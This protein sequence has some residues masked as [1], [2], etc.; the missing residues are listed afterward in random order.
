M[1]EDWYF[2]CCIKAS[3]SSTSAFLS[4]LETLENPETDRQLLYLA[5]SELQ[6]VDSWM[7]VYG[8][9]H[10][11]NSF[12]HPNFP[13]SKR[14][15][16]IKPYLDNLLETLLDNNTILKRLIKKLPGKLSDYEILD[17][18]RE[19]VQNYDARKHDHNPSQ[20]PYLDLKTFLSEIVILSI[21]DSEIQIRSD[22]L[23]KFSTQ[24]KNKERETYQFIR[25]CLDY[26][27]GRLPFIL[28]VSIAKNAGFESEELK[29]CFWQLSEHQSPCT[30]VLEPDLL[31][32]YIHNIYFNEIKK[33][34]S[35]KDGKTTAPY[36][37]IQEELLLLRHFSQLFNKSSKSMEP[38]S[39]LGFAENP[40]LLET[41]PVVYWQCI[42]WEVSAV[43]NITETAKALKNV[44]DIPQEVNKTLEVQYS[45]RQENE[46]WKQH[47]ESLLTLREPGSKINWTESSNSCILE[48]H[49]WLFVSPWIERYD[50]QPQRKIDNRYRTALKPENLIRL[51]VGLNIATKI[52]QTPKLKPSEGNPYR[53]FIIHASDIIHKVFGKWL[54]T[55][56]DGQNTDVIQLTLPLTGLAL[57]ADRETK[58]VG[59]GH[60]QSI[61]PESFV[62]IL[63]DASLEPIQNPIEQNFLDLVCPEVLI[64]WI[65]DAYP[66]AIRGR[67]SARWLSLISEVYGYY[68]SGKHPIGSRQEAALVVRFLSIL[69]DFNDYRPFDWRD[70]DKPRV[71]AH[72]RVLLLSSPDVTVTEWQDWDAYEKQLEGDWQLSSRIVRSLQ[73]LQTLAKEYPDRNTVPPDCRPWLSEW[74]H[75]LNAVSK[76]MG[77]DRFTRLLLVE[78]LDNPLLQDPDSQKQIAYILLEYGCAYDLQKLLDYAFP[79]GSKRDFCD[80]TIK[81]FDLQATIINAMQVFLE[82]QAQRFISGQELRNVQDPKITRIAFQKAELFQATL[83]KVAHLCSSYENERL[84]AFC[85]KSTQA[86]KDE[87]CRNEI[88]LR[89]SQYAVELKNNIKQVILP[90]K[91][92]ITDV[93]CEA[94]TYDPN[95]YV[96]NVLHYDFDLKGIKNFFSQDKKSENYCHPSSGVQELKVVAIAVGKKTADSNLGGAQYCYTFNCGLDRYYNYL[97]EELGPYVALTLKP[98]PEPESREWYVDSATSLIPQLKVGDIKKLSV[99]KRPDQENFTDII[100]RADGQKLKERQDYDLVYWKADTSWYFQ[101][102]SLSS[103]DDVFAQLDSDKKWRPY[104]HQFSDLVLD[105]V[106]ASGCQA[107]SGIITLCFINE[108]VNVLGDEAWRFSTAPG[109][110]F[111]IEKKKFDKESKKKISRE[112]KK[113]SKTFEIANGLLI[114]VRPVISSDNQEVYLELDRFERRNLEWR[115]LFS[116]SQSERNEVFLAERSN[117]DDGKWYYTLDD[118]VV[119]G[120]PEKVRVS[121]QKEREISSDR[122][123]IEFIVREWNPGEA[124]VK[125]DFVESFEV[126]PKNDWQDFFKR[127]ICYAASPYQTLLELRQDKVFPFRNENSSVLMCF[128]SDNILVQVQSESLSMKMLQIEDRL[129]KTRPRFRK[130]ETVSIKWESESIILPSESLPSDLNYQGRYLGILVSI[131]KRSGNL[132]RIL[133]SFKQEP[134]DIQIENPPRNIRPGAVI[135]A[136]DEAGKF[137]CKTP[138]FIRTRALWERVESTEQVTTH[139]LGITQNTGEAIAEIDSGKFTVLNKKLG[140]IT[141]L[142]QISGSK[143]EGQWD[144]PLEVENDIHGSSWYDKEKKTQQQRSILSIKSNDGDKDFLIGNCREGTPSGTL[145]LAKI[146]LRLFQRDANLYALDREFILE[147][148]ERQHSKEAGHVQRLSKTSEHYQSLLE[149]YWNAPRDLDIH[150]DP[151]KETI[152]IMEGVNSLKVPSQNLGQS[153]AWTDQVLVAPDEG[154][155][156]FFQLEEREYSRKGKARLFKGDKGEALASFRRVSSYRLEEFR[157][158][159]SLSIDELIPIRDQYLKLYFVGLHAEGTA[160]LFEWGYGQTLLVSRDRL[161][162]RGEKFNQADLL[163]FY[164]DLITAIRLIPIEARDVHIADTS[165]LDTENT[166]PQGELILDIQEIDLQYNQRRALY[167]ER[168]NHQIIH[169]LYIKPSLLIS[170]SDS[171]TPELKIEAVHGFNEFSERSGRFERIEAKLAPDPNLDKYLKRLNILSEEDQEHVIF[172]RLDTQEYE[173]SDGKNLIF[174]HISLSFDNEN[175]QSQ[176]WI[177]LKAGEIR[178]TRDGNDKYLEVLPPENLLDISGV[179]ENMKRLILMR[180]QFSVREDI[181][182]RVSE[183]KSNKHFKGNWLLVR[184][185]P[186]GDDRFYLSLIDSPPCRKVTV[187]NR[188]INANANSLVTI[189]KKHGDGS[190]DD[191]PIEIEFKPGVFFKLSAELIEQRPPFL[192]SGDIVQLTKQLYPNRRYKFRVARASLG[193]AHYL[194]ENKVRPAVALPTGSLRKLDNL[195][196]N[197]S[198]AIGSLP[199][200]KAS[201]GHYQRKN[202]A[203]HKLTTEEFVNSESFTKLMSHRHPKL[204]LLGRSGES[205]F[206]CPLTSKFFH[207][208]VDRIGKCFKVNHVGSTSSQEIRDYHLLTFADQSREQLLRRAQRESWTYHDNTSFYWIPENRELKTET[209]DS[210]TGPVFFQ[211]LDAQLR[212]RYTPKEFHRFGFPA[213]ELIDLLGKKHRQSFTFSVAGI[214]E[215]EEGGLWL[216]LAPGRLV[217]VTAPLMVWKHYGRE[218]DLNNFVWQGFAPGDLIKLQLINN[219]MVGGLLR[220]E[221]IR[222]VD[223]KPGPRKVF[224]EKRCFLPVQSIDSETGSLQ[225][226]SGKYALTLPCAENYSPLPTVSLTSANE[227]LEVSSDTLSKNLPTKGD[228]VL[229]SLDQVSKNPIIV[230]I[231]GIFPEPEQSYKC[232]QDDGFSKY[233]VSFEDGKWH[234]DIRS[235]ESLLDLLATETQQGA[236]PVMVESVKRVSKT[237]SQHVLFFSLSNHRSALELPKGGISLAR[238]MG[239][240]PD[241]QTGLLQ[242]NSGLFTLKMHQVIFGLPST[243]NLDFMAA[244]M[245]ANQVSPIGLHRDTEGTLR[246]GFERQMNNEFS[247]EVLGVV[248]T[249]QIEE[250]DRAI[251]LICRSI[252]TMGLYWLPTKNAALAPLTPTQLESIFVNS[253]DS[254]EVVQVGNISSEISVIDRQEIKNQF[255][256]LKIGEELGVTVVQDSKSLADGKHQCLVKIPTTGV[257]LSCL[258]YGQ[259]LDRGQEILVEVTQRVKGT[260]KSVTVV[261]LGK[262]RK[263]LDLPNSWVENFLPKQGHSS[264]AFADFLNWNSEGM[265]V[266][267]DIHASHQL[268]SLHRALHIAYFDAFKGLE[269]T[270][271]R[272]PR[273]QYSVAMTGFRQFS[274]QAQISIVPAVMNVLL[275]NHIGEYALVHQLIKNLGQRARRS[276][277]VDVLLFSWVRDTWQEEEEGLFQR[278]SELKEEI[279]KT[280]AFEQKLETVEM[281]RRFYEAVSLRRDTLEGEALTS[282]SNGLAASIGL[283]CDLSQLLEEAEINQTLIN[284]YNQVIFSENNFNQ[285]LHNSHVEELKTLLNKILHQGLDLILLD[286]IKISHDAFSI[287]APYNTLGDCSDYLQEDKS[288]LL[289]IET[290][291]TQLSQYYEELKTY[292]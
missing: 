31:K 47:L 60:L 228:V 230:G 72:H 22:L 167:E 268:S 42:L 160:Y 135:C 115:S 32:S 189:A 152:K 209:L 225:L 234:L 224:G 164:G 88:S 218:R 180:R 253:E 90:K 222:L 13:D 34:G 185:I 244:W 232:W 109:K 208:E 191:E 165:D 276:L 245:Q 66:S 251:G 178:S 264:S 205:T 137:E 278:L 290:M 221:R 81:N 133:W 265:P 157:A 52:L 260:S 30:L 124:E 158:E 261:P 126:K 239:L 192:G 117:D 202:I 48:H 182:K 2:C 91:E 240:W 237:S 272:F 14:I 12:K 83:E 144:F 263:I 122:E 175:I 250:A 197:N 227:L 98:K 292:F 220:P 281:I 270:K 119:S 188:I 277:H 211:R 229:L 25:D 10:V 129:S 85:Q 187:L 214:S 213:R 285:A 29:Q 156:I 3:P 20:T 24:L 108:D 64:S 190:T 200:I 61:S 241:R 206:I 236:L 291:T 99:S 111:L 231:E 233:L 274:D 149:D 283:K 56:S 35:K 143:V 128:T 217:E 58:L 154:T 223:W 7:Q 288:I 201:P 75:C 39:R 120:F 26:K 71:K 87:K 112:I 249:S 181:L 40:R 1:L 194:P 38:I 110:N 103:F 210:Q 121:F 105:A 69:Y 4:I 171:F 226:G 257:I 50:H 94:V 55:Y 41:L 269:N 215:L 5:Y 114:S 132:F 101:P 80:S 207:G 184:F 63:R 247:V 45:S 89:Q 140:K 79:A 78:L 102:D 131:P 127:W 254:F 49:R 235:L 67:N 279:C 216:E 286:P 62:Q 17:A 256:K 23:E 16:T 54:K 125:A 74:R 238:L 153:I 116:R 195:Y 118:L 37:V 77:L 107:D 142:A 246:T 65:S 51:V 9:P 204:V 173:K 162:F 212:L 161:R 97:C 273:F 176:D 36:Q 242:C 289:L 271:D 203:W 73:Q 104:D 43:Y 163:L 199:N 113:C 100:L 145:R 258:T 86:K 28:S 243:L 53:Q 27:C 282:I 93:F 57:F 198:F 15:D 174:K 134:M 95:N 76:N 166:T 169:I 259:S 146:K 92:E 186:K 262:K 138:V 130:A 96:A 59:P 150:F 155:Y 139:Y 177:F 266:E 106:D 267:M 46:T 136:S 21:I 6:R 141:H 284:I 193:D 219:E 18:F 183:A 151:S 248:S 255:E 287:S 168:K 8:L 84:T 148:V 275:L 68:T 19:T 44:W 252:D 82:E 123:K 33:A 179:S 11:L 147:E 280:Q 196:S 159:H 170:A 172:G 70:K